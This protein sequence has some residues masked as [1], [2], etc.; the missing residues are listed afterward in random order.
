MI[1]DRRSDDETAAPWPPRHG[2]RPTGWAVALV[3]AALLAGCAGT[4]ERSTDCADIRYQAMPA[5]VAPPEVPTPSPAGTSGSTALGLGPGDE[6]TVEVF[7][8]PDMTATVRLTS[9]GTAVLPL[10]GSIML[11]GL[12]PSEAARAIEDRYRNGSYFDDPQVNLSV[13]SHRSRRVAV[14]GEV[15]EPGLYPLESRISLL[16]G[17]ALA[18]GIKPTGASAVIV[19]YPDERAQRYVPLDLG[20][21]LGDAGNAEPVLMLEGNETLIVPEAPRFYIYGE[22]QRPDAYPLRPGTTVMQAISLGGGVTELGSRKRI[23]MRRTSEGST[24]ARSAT[25]TDCVQPDDVI[26]VKERIF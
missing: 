14:L 26:Y 7:G 10:I 5:T 6:V 19:R 16:E 24:V 11:V 12:E 22:V 9:A 20:S 17:L 15:S 13:E 8:H 23:E 1:A 4:V 18:G 2:R 3:A 25:L 21:F